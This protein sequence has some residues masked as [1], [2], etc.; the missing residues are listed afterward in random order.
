MTYQRDHTSAVDIKEQLSPYSLRYAFTY[1]AVTYYQNQ[2]FTRQEAL[3]QASIDLGHGEL[4]GRY[5]ENVY[6][7]GI[8][9]V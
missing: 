1:D 9:L 8:K 3:A 2:G 5:V 4:R 7:I 6:S